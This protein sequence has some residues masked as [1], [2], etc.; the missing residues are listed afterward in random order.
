M[1]TCLE[2]FSVL[3]DLSHDAAVT[4]SSALA[5]TVDYSCSY[6]GQTACFKP[7]GR[8]VL[9]TTELKSALLTPATYFVW[10]QIL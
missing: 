9:Y 8:I 1:Y 7:R 4:L 5:T 6:I 3:S 10:P 2:P